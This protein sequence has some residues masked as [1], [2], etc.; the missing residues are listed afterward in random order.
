MTYVFLSPE[1]IEAAR[2]IRAELGELATAPV[3]LAMNLVI[4]EV[5]FGDSPLHAHLDTTVG[6]LAL[7]YG[8]HPAPDLIITVDWT[9]AKALLIEGRPQAAMSAFMAGKVRVEGDMSKLVALQGAAP[10]PASEGVVLR[11]REITA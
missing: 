6:V 10:D 3:A 2:A 8:H 4:T 7:E 1:W 9:T 11:L 5:P